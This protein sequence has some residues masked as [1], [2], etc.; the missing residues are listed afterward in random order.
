M[1]PVCGMRRFRKTRRPP[2]SELAGL[3]A[4]A[5]RLR[6]AAPEEPELAAALADYD[7][8]EVRGASGNLLEWWCP[9]GAPP[10]AR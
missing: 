8:W 7:M 5:A 10:C 1:P 2:R 6:A 9:I 4:D 3:V